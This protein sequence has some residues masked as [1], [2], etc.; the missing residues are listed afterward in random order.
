[1]CMKPLP[2]G[3]NDGLTPIGCLDSKLTW[4]EDGP[5]PVR[6]QFN[7]DL[8]SDA[9]EGLTH[10]NG[11]ESSIGFAKRHDGCPTYEWPDCIRNLPLKKEI[12]HLGDKA[13]QK[14][15]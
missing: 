12:H 8:A 15:R 9:P 1:M 14:I 11:T 6:D 2:G 5:R 3:V 4:F 13:I 10:R 7:R